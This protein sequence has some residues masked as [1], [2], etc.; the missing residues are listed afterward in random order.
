MTP[1]PPQKRSRRLTSWT[2]SDEG[3]LSPTPTVEALEGLLTRVAAGA[4]SPQEAATLLRGERN[5]SYASVDLARLERRGVGEVIF[6]E[7][8]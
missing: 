4:I 2:Q 3:Q 7:G 5:L 1:S 8:K 6:G